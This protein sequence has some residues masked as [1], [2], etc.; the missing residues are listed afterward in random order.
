MTGDSSVAEIR[1]AMANWDPAS[2]RAALEEAQAELA[3]S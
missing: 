2:I 3:R 1:A